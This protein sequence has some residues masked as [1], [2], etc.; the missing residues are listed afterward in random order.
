MFDTC[1]LGPHLNDNLLR[2]WCLFGHK[3][4]VC[5]DEMMI[6]NVSFDFEL[7][8]QQH[9]ISSATQHSNLYSCSLLVVKST[10]MLSFFTP[11][12]PTNADN[13]HFIIEI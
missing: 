13:S 8:L 5:A 3:E 4:H 12:R 9:M 2:K 1:G 6:R 7:L 10:S 11:S